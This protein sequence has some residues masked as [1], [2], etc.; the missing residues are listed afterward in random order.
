MLSL[1]PLLLEH[2]KRIPLTMYMSMSRLPLIV[3]A[4]VPKRTRY[5]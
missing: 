5:N 4:I 1:R 2:L 3:L